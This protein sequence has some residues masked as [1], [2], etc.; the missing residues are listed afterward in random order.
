MNLSILLWLPLAVATISLVLPGAASRYAAIPGA[1]AACV[2]AVVTVVRF[3]TGTVG[4]QFATDHLWIREL[5]IHYKLG[6]DGLNLFLILLA[7]VLFLASAI[8]ASFTE[9]ERPGLFFFW[10][11]LAERAC[12]AR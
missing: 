11:G 8:W 12:S 9:W 7:T 6:I 2:L 10:F 3:K 5:G 4:L 1:L